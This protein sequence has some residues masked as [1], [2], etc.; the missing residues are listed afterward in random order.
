MNTQNTPVHIKLWHRG[1]WMVAIANFMVA[2]AVYAFIPVLAPWT[3]ETKGFDNIGAGLSFFAF[4]L[5]LFLLGPFCSYLVQRYRRNKVCIFSIALMAL[6]I[7]IMYWINAKNHGSIDYY[8][9]F[10]QRLL[11]GAFFGL[12]QM[13]LTSTLVVDTCES[14]LRTEANHCVSWFSRMS[15]SIGPMLGLLL[16][17]TQ[18]IESVISLSLIACVIAA[19]LVAITE[20]P[21]RAPEESIH[22]LSLDRF[23]LTNGKILFANLILIN[24]SIGIIFSMSLPFAFYG[25]MMGGFLLALLAQRFMFRNA[26]LKSEVV[27]ALFFIIAAIVLLLTKDIE[28]IILIV[29]LFVGFGIGIIGSRFLLFFIKLSR[30]CQ[31][32]TSQSTFMLAWESGLAIGIG[33][34]LLLSVF[35]NI[36][37]LLLSL[38]LSISSLLIYHFHTHG[39]YMHHKNR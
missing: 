12:A 10:L 32:G 31:R 39:W 18:G 6:S 3:I 28:K 15:L 36:V 35:G 29:P 26:D 13:V 5:G 34:G 17:N 23:F 21:F 4:G 8:L 9:I 25:F 19:V 2:F 20:F 30:H 11:L 7:A 1:F 22:H 37:S 27:T 33:I 16:Y 14:F 24:I 38:V